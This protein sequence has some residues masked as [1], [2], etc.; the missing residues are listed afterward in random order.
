MG[1]CGTSNVYPEIDQAESIEE[2]FNNL[3]SKSKE[4]E[5]EIQ[6]ITN[7]L[8]DRSRIPTKFDVSVIN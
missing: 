7:Y 2:L 1:C 6:Q 8:K 4:C 5:E 3:N